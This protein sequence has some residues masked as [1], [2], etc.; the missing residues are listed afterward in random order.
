L[1]RTEKAVKEIARRIK[2]QIYTSE[3]KFFLVACMNFLKANSV[4]TKYMVM[5]RGQNA[6][7]NHKKI[8]NTFFERVEGFKFWE[9]A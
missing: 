4:K 2:K 5:A 9:Q 8:C 7:Q 1:S 3:G 6:G